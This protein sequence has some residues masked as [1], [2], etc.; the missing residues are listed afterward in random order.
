MAFSALTSSVNLRAAP[1][2]ILKSRQPA[3][4]AAKS[5]HLSP[6]FRCLDNNKL[7]NPKNPRINDRPQPKTRPTTPSTSLSPELISVRFPPRPIAGNRPD[8]CL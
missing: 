5:H 2:S 7:A 3:S 6:R 8:F 4:A 1:L